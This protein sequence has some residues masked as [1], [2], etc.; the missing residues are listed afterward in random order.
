MAKWYFNKD[1]VGSNNGTSPE[2]AWVS[3]FVIVW[4]SVA[5]G[6]VIEVIHG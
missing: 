2:N 4:E 6:D 5:D 1:A 3:V